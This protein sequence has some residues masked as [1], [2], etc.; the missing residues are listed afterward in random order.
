MEPKQLKEERLK[1]GLTQ[2]EFSERLMT[3][4]ETYSKWERGVRR[5]PGMIEVALKAVK[6]EIK[7]ER[8]ER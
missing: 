2:L 4:F 5:V 1:L 8:G 3:P 7:K 6:D